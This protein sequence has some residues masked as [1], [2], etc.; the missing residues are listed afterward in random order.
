MRSMQFWKT[1]A[2]SFGKV[3]V[4]HPALQK[5]HTYGTISLIAEVDGTRIAFTGD[6]MTSGGKL[7]QLDAMEYNYSDLLGVEFTLQSVIA[8]KKESV[9]IAYPSHGPPIT[10]VKADIG[11]L[12][13]RLEALAGIGRLFTSGRSS[14]LSDGQ[15]LP[16]SR[17]PQITEHL[18]WA[19]PYSCSNFCVVLSGSGHAMLID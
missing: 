8:L 19:G 1:T 11:K 15:T 4:P 7:Y 18:L 3:R 16:E 12:E 6:L 5:G 10:E 17:L 2:P 14:V 9:E 13:S